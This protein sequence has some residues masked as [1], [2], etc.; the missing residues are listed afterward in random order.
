MRCRR[1]IPNI[2]SFHAA[3]GKGGERISPHTARLCGVK[4]QK[5]RPACLSCAAALGTQSRVPHCTTSHATEPLEALHV[6][7]AGPYEPSADA[8]RFIACF[9]DG[10]SRHESVYGMR[11]EEDLLSTLDKYTGDVERMKCF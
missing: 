5:D 4:L 8:L 7:T 1:K 3:I 2:D 11:S 10:N 9:V 6:G